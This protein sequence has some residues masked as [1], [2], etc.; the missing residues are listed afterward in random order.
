MKTVDFY[1]G[2]LSSYAYLAS[3]A[4]PELCERHGAQARFRPVLLAGLL[5]HWGQLGPAEIAPKGLFAFRACLRHARLR[6]IPFRAPKYH[7]FNPL[8]A[9]RA[10]IAT[11]SDEARMRAA[12]ALYA[13]GW[14]EGGDVGDPTEP[15]EDFRNTP[16][17]TA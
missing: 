2:Y 6:A 1:F 13:L 12:Q 5:N 17:L 14:A 16:A 10:T 4:I 15:S 3:L 8:K 9:L 7:P 11:D